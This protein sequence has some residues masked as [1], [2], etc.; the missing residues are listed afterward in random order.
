MK[1]TRQEHINK[2]ADKLCILKEE[3]EFFKHGAEW[4]IEQIQPEWI[5]VSERLPDRGNAVLFHCKR[6]YEKNLTV[7][8]GWRQADYNGVS[9]FASIHMHEDEDIIVTH[10]MPLPEPPQ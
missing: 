8:I 4:A 3:T 10:W 7:V 5:P 6:E 9:Q 2:A 1:H